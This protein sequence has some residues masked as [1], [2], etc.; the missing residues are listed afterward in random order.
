MPA[1]P[2]FSTRCRAVTVVL[3][4]SLYPLQRTS[5]PIRRFDG[6]SAGLEA[7]EKSENRNRDLTIVRLLA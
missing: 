1:I 6:P 3:R 7:L 2:N 5:E 4:R